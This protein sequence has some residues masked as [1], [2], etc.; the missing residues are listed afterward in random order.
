MEEAIKELKENAAFELQD[1]D[2]IT[3]EVYDRDPQTGGGHG[4]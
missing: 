1:D 3:I 4:E 2:F